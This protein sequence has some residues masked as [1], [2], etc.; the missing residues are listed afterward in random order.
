MCEALLFCFLLSPILLL[1]ISVFFF[2][3]SSRSSRPQCLSACLNLY[4]SVFR[5]NLDAMMFLQR[6]EVMSVCNIENAR[7]VGLK[8]GIGFVCRDEKPFLLSFSIHGYIHPYLCY[9]IAPLFSIIPHETGLSFVRP[10]EYAARSFGIGAA[11]GS[12]PVPGVMLIQMF[13]MSS[14]TRHLH[15]VWNSRFTIRLHV[16]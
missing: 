6:L 8:G 14:S 11:G 4:L 2:F 9:D 10:S 15:G 16:M 7:S 13:S 3:P 12:L 1:F 5:F